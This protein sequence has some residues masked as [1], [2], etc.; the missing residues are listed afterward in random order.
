MHIHS[1]QVYRQDYL[2]DMDSRSA[3]SM[4]W[5]Y[6]DDDPASF[7]KLRRSALLLCGRDG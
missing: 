4:S 2:S 3:L 5:S 7:S 6:A 1:S